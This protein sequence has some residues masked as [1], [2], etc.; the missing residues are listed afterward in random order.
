MIILSGNIIINEKKEIY[1]IYRTKWNHL[2]TPGGKLEKKD[3]ENY[4]T[5]TITELK[6]RAK[7]ELQEEVKGIQIIN[8]SYFRK[9]EFR[10]PDGRK[11]TAH[12]FITKIEGN[13]EPNEQIFNKKKSK[14]Y[15]IQELENKKMSPDLKLLL[16]KIKQYLNNPSTLKN[17]PNY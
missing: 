11:A 10:I 6:N 15:T 9:Q 4:E 8:T 5:P 13:P 7:T 1:L 12:K 3:C 14:Y 16:P 2:E 17:K